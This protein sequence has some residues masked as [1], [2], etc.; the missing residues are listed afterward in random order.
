VLPIG[1][2]RRQVLKALLGS[3]LGVLPVFASGRD[4]AQKPLSLGTTP[5]FLDDQ[6]GL[7]RQWKV[8]LAHATGRKVDFVQ[9]G[10]YQ[11]ITELLLADQVD[12]AWVCGY[13]YVVHQKRL[14]LVAVPVYQQRPLYRSYLIVPSR[15]TASRSILDLRGKVFAFSDPWSNSGH[16]V[17]LCELIKVRERPE[18]VFRR[19]FFTYAHRKVIEAVAVGVAD[20]GEVDGYV[21]DTLAKQNDPLTA[22][23][24]VAWRSAE[25]GFPPI[26]AR[27]GLP[28]DVF[29]QIQS[30]L[31]GM[32]REPAGQAVLAALNLDGFTA[33]SPALFDGIRA[34]VR[35]AGGA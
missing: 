11:E 1:N 32:S 7:L 29:M 14:R 3:S 10:S 20:G 35:L 5:V 24:R 6:L 19:F 8:Q 30:A 2:V 31:L 12:T 34:S 4:D 33:G 21:W 25:Y 23:T 18:T 16:L 13:P 15:D 17:P 9:R 27:P 26:V 28:D 22:R